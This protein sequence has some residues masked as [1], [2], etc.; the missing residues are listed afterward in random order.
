MLVILNFM[1]LVP[2]TSGLYCNSNDPERLTFKREKNMENKASSRHHS[3][4]II[5][6]D[7]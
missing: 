4:H 5:I 3:Y 6:Y 1:I 7:D 2:L